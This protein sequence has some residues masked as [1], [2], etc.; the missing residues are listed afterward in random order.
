MY[1]QI[2]KVIGSKM[3]SSQSRSTD[4]IA[5][6]VNA[7]I[8]RLENGV[9]PVVTST[10]R[11]DVNR[12][13]APQLEK[14]SQL[15]P[16]QRNLLIESIVRRYKDASIKEHE[17]VGV[18]A[19]L[20]TGENLTQSSLQSHHH[21]G[22][23]RGAAG[24]DRIEEITNMRNKSNI[25]KVITTPHRIGSDVATFVPRSKMEVNEI[26]NLLV[27]VL[28]NDIVTD[29]RIMSAPQLPQP[30]IGGILYRFPEW[31]HIYTSIKAIPLTALKQRWMRIFI[32]SDLIFKHRISL[33]A[34]ALVVSENVKEGGYVLYPPSQVGFYI[35]VHLNVISDADYYVKLSNIQSL[36]VGGI[37][38][39][40][41]A[42]PIPENLL[43]NLRIEEVN[44]ATGIEGCSR[45]YELVS[46]AP[47]FIPPFV[48]ER[49]IKSMVPDA[50]MV[51]SSGK[52]FCS[53]E[54]IDRLREMILQTPII[55]ADVID[56]RTKIPINID[57]IN[58]STGLPYRQEIVEIGDPEYERILSTG[59]AIR[60]TFRQ[61]LF[62]KYPYLEHADL[63]TRYFL[64]DDEANRF[65]LEVM[66]EYHFFWYIE[67]ICSR[68]QD[69]YVL[70]EV[71]SMRTY[72]TSPLD[73][74]D[75][76]G[77]MAMRNMIY[78]EFRENIGINPIH[79]KVII[80]NMTLYKEPVS[81]RRQSVKNDKSEWMTFTTFEDVLK[82]ITFAAFA[83][84]EDNMQSVSSRVLTGMPITI[85]RGG[86]NMSKTSK[87][88]PTGNS[89]IELKL[90]AQ[91]QRE[92]TRTTETSTRGRGTR[93][94]R[95]RGVSNPVAVVQ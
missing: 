75:T 85:G 90:Q 45:I 68:V 24:F 88:N 29:Y 22:L 54:R 76:L 83:G 63:T 18:N 34:I 37:E 30:G 70:P 35:D 87:D 38:S 73:C 33:P 47:A 80:N 39:V 20:T 74:R 91:R 43:T 86:I 9:F 72:T 36:Q 84:E 49:M 50:E 95:G 31:Y 1:N 61:D 42:V 55:Y 41:N 46:S 27:K 65:L 89:F 25:V 64:T 62:D 7:V 52:R 66:V 5:S 56:S 71:D 58:P 12:M 77:Y 59:T 10:L 51:G 23:K 15:T 19:A 32:N 82:Y 2:E 21:A 13:I 69:L 8:S 17:P 26:A 44:S 57:D 48:W 16:I 81:I 92:R 4:L 11:D 78:R 40:E 28:M 53:S 94:G 93:R 14:I 67:A 79:V 3:D 60:I 6:V